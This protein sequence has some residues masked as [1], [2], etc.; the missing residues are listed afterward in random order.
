MFH[1]LCDVTAEA[2]KILHSDA[3]KVM[4]ISHDTND[5]N[6]QKTDQITYMLTLS[7]ELPR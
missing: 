7:A 1:G 3:K 4:T 6:S 5:K 2:P